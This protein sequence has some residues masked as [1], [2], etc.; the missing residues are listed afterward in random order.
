MIYQPFITFVLME[1]KKEKPELVTSIS[2]DSFFFQLVRMRKAMVR[3]SNQLMNEAGIT[4]PL[5]QLPLIVI[6]QKKTTLTQR[7]LSDITLRD[8]SSI[9]RSVNALVKK[10]LLLVEQDSIDKRKNNISLSTKGAA[11][12][13]TLRSLMNMA[14]NEVL[15]VFSDEERVIAYN[16]LKGYANR[17]EN[18]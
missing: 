12:A 17:L 5:E 9:L 7:E 8:K 15:S 4:L 1:P 14:E 13:L 11:L 10:G 6:L 3:K 16:T 18:L 2:D